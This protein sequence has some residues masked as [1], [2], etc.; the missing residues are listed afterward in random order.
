MRGLWANGDEHRGTGVTLSTVRTA[1]LRWPDRAHARCGGSGVGERQGAVT[2]DGSRVVARCGSRRRALE[3]A[4]AKQSARRQPERVK[5]LPGAA[6][7]RGHQAG[8]VKTTPRRGQTL[9]TR[10][11]V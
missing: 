4:S 8:M 3:R 10:S 5:T 11:S 6:S 7:S 1:L 2:G 9:S